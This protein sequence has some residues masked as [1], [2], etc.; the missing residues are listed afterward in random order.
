MEGF[1]R[2]EMED[3]HACVAARRGLLARCGGPLVLCVA[4]FGCSSESPPRATH[5]RQDV[6]ALDLRTLPAPQPVAVEERVRD[7][8]TGSRAGPSRPPRPSADERPSDGPDP[9]E[10]P[11]GSSEEA[12][13]AL[14]RL[15]LTIHDGPPLA[16]VGASG[17][18]ID[19]IDLGS[20]YSQRR[21]CHGE[22][23]GFSIARGDQVNVCFRVVHNREQ[24]DVTV[25]WEKDGDLAKRRRGVTIPA[26]HAYR[27]RAFLV[28]RREYAARWTVRIYSQD[29]VELASA[30]FSVVDGA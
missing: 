19:A 27:S 29:D 10:A 4:A 25:V 28:L 22:R 16:G 9:R 12:A 26:R 6:A 3:G 14:R 20:E 7:R 15:P 23:D 5:E 13:R 11:P 17:I 21:G 18:H 24:E 2:R 1:W 8:R 30:S